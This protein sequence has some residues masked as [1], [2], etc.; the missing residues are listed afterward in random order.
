MMMNGWGLLLLGI[1]R[2][3]LILDGTSFSS[4]FAFRPIYHLS[5]A[6]S[7]RMSLNQGDCEDIDSRVEL[8][9]DG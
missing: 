6:S 7:S 2:R 8:V 4:Q 9:A 1:G 3:L 5:F